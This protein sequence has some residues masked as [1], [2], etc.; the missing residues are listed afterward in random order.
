MRELKPNKL[1][2]EEVLRAM[3]HPSRVRE[4][5]LATYPDLNRDWLSHPSRVRELKPCLIRQPSC[6]ILVAPLAG[7]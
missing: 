7:A 2:E 1:G 3:S 5:K 6:C 4:L